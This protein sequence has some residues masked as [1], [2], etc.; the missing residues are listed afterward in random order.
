VWNRTACPGTRLLDAETEFTGALPGGNLTRDLI[1]FGSGSP[2]FRTGAVLLP[3][4]GVEDV[5]LVD[6]KVCLVVG[7]FGPKALSPELPE[8][9]G[10]ASDLLL[11]PENPLDEPDADEKRL[12]L[13]LVVPKGE[14]LDVLPKPDESGG[15]FWEKMF[16]PVLLVAKGDAPDVLPKPLESGGGLAVK[17]FTPG[18]FAVTGGSSDLLLEPTG[19]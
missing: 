19:A 18:L 10:D 6:P 1:L 4:A 14:G 9:N 2:S 8:P 16:V 7:D 17:M 5:E 3:N 15:E 13:E 12:V 11:K